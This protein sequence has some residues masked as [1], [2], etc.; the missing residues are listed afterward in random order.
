MRALLAA[1]AMAALLSCSLGLASAAP[2]SVVLELKGEPGQEMK[3]DTKLDFLM[4]IEVRNPETTEQIVKLE[5]SLSASLV[6]IARITEVADNGDLTFEGQL[7]SFA[8]RMVL[9]DLRMDL[10][11]QGPRGGPPELIK[12]PPMPI[13][14]VISKRG[15]P[16]ALKGLEKIPIPPLPG[17][18]GQ[19]IDLRQMIASGLE[20]FAQPAFPELPV[21]VGDSWTTEVVF[22]LAEMT[23]KMGLE[24]PPEA[25]G[26]LSY[27][28]VPMSM[29]YTLA[30]FEMVGDVECAKVVMESSW[31]IAMPVAP[32]IMLREG[33]DTMQTTWLDYE[34]GQKVKD[35]L[36][37]TAR[38][39][40][41]TPESTFAQ[42][43]MNL[44]AKSEMR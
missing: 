27:A 9:A 42:M 23:A 6:S 28:R 19:Q 39:K 2:E 36:E 14:A 12:L 13:Q 25:T 21:S 17:P 34:A 26:M 8:I 20:T 43:E 41:G 24:L 22:D 31:Q 38:M 4:D 1:L 32:G 15:Q 35:L 33:A 7:E 10:S 44:R 16:L 37:V 3:Y 18:G 11:L 30:G 29:T 5:P 40:A